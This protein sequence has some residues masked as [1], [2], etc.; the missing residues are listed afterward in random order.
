ML[1]SSGRLKDF[2]AMLVIGDGLMAVLRPR[3]HAAAWKIGPE[4]WN[5][6]MQCLQERPALTRTIGIAQTTVG[7]CW[8]L[9]QQGNDPHE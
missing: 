7:M 1:I 6:F 9:A 8:A 2:A 5:N 3:G 4:W